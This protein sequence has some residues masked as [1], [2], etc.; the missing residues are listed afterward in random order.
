[1]NGGYMSI[2]HKGSEGNKGPICTEVYNIMDRLNQ[3]LLDLSQSD[4]VPSLQNSINQCAKDLLL[5]INTHRDA[6]AKTESFLKNAIIDL[7]EVPYM[8]V[9]M[10]KIAF[11][12]AIRAS[13]KNL[14]SFL[15]NN[16]SL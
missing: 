3:L 14:E 7:T 1:M 8:Q 4:D 9:Q 12:V 16:T 2:A 10:Q 5:V 11:E 13:V 15:D 6:I